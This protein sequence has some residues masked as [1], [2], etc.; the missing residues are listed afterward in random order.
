M[1]EFKRLLRGG[2]VVEG[3][4]G[5][6]ELAINNT[7]L[8]RIAVHRAAMPCNHRRRFLLDGAEGNLDNEL[9]AVFEGWSGFRWYLSYWR[10]GQQAVGA[11]GGVIT[12]LARQ[13]WDACAGTCLL[14][15]LRRK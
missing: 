13:S 14:A 8:P 12:V 9:T 2:E 1:F 6:H 7:T 5:V 10:R 4:G 3:G 11:G 15:V